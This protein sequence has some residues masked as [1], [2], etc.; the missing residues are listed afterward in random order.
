MNSKG[1]SGLILPYLNL[2]PA[3]KFFIFLLLFIFTYHFFVFFIWRPSKKK[4]LFWQV[5]VYIAG[6]WGIFLL[7][8]INYRYYQL[9]FESK[10]S[11]RV[12]YYLIRPCIHSATAVLAAC[13]ISIIIVRLFFKQQLVKK[14][15]LVHGPLF[16][17]PDAPRDEGFPA[18]KYTRKVLPGQISE[19]AS[20][21]NRDILIPFDSLSRTSTIIGDMGSGKSRLMYIFQDAIR[22]YYPD[23]P[24]LIHDPKGEWLRTYYNPETDVIFAPYDKR[25]CAWQLW[26]DFNRYPELRFS[27][28]STAVESHHSG[29]HDVFWSHSAT[30]LLKDASHLDTIEDARTYLYAEKER[31]ETDN[32]FRSIFTT[33]LIAFRDMVAVELS[34][35]RRG[36]PALSIDDFLHFPGRIFLLNNPACAAEQHGALTLLLSAFLLRAISLPDVAAGELRAAAIIDETLTF[37]LPAAVELPVYSQCRSKGLAIIASAQRLPSGKEHGAWASHSANIFG[38]KVSDLATRKALSERIGIMRYNEPQKSVSSGDKSVSTTKSHIQ[39]GH[40]A[41]APEDF[42][43]LNSREFI[44]FHDYGVSPG[45]V[46]NVSKEQRDIKPFIYNDR[47]DV[48]DFM[49]IL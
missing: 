47:Q 8:F 29:N 30:A 44:L 37:R 4:L 34:A 23:I 11:H 10:Y 21:G 1:M 40:A 6:L 24:I 39:R 36:R 15:K 22:K 46:S 20:G 48:S 2:P 19:F 32:T 27:V 33:S 45:I 5:I 7:K 9:L 26:E 16:N 38:M 43:K 25:S 18:G 14:K 17:N 12:Y 42:G 31:N 28:I 3:Q 13:A 35:R 49:S 41:L